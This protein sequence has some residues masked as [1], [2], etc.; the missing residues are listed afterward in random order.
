MGYPVLGLGIALGEMG[1]R[2]RVV[3]WSAISKFLSIARCSREVQ[4]RERLLCMATTKHK[5]TGWN[6][7]STYQRGSGIPMTSS[8]GGWI[9]LH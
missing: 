1:C 5:D 3:F 9:T 6:L 2:A 7:L 4:G 8:T